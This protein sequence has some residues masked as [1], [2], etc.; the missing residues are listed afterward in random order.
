[1]RSDRSA[2][3]WAG[4]MHYVEHA[5]WQTG[6]VTNLTQHVCRHWRQLAR[7]GDGGI[8][9]GDGRRDFPAQ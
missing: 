4:A 5:I 3:V 8:A 9:D 7:L 6:F 1:M 2:N